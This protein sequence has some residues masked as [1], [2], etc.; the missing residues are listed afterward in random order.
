MDIQMKSVPI[1]STNVK[2]RKEQFGLLLVS[3]RTPILAL[4]EDSAMIWNCFDGRSSVGE[5]ARKLQ[6][7]LGGDLEETEEAVRCFV[8]SC[9]DLGLIEIQADNG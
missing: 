7:E 9:Y 8:E 3:K 4:N 2:V 5:I 6:A 1:A